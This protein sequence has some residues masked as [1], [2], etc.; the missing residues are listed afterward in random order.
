MSSRLLTPFI[1][2]TVW[3][4]HSQFRGFGSSQTKFLLRRATEEYNPHRVC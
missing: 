4:N 2:H 3:S 1:L